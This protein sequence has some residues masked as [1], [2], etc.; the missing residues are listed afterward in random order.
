MRVKT[1][2]DPVIGCFPH[3]TE[4]N[5]NQ[6]LTVNITVKNTLELLAG[7]EKRKHFEI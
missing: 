4:F 1:P 6:D 7:E 3:F 2:G 5:F